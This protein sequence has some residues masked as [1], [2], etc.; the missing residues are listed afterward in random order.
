MPRSTKPRRPYKPGTVALNA[1]QIAINRVGKLNPQ[2]ARGQIQLARR[3]LQEFS[4]GQHCADH[5]RSLAD[6]A[7]MAETLCELGIGSGRAA[8]GVIDAA[9]RALAAVMTRQRERQTWTLY[10]AELDALGWLIS[11]HQTQ[12]QECDYGEFDTAFRRT[13]ERLAQ[14]RAGNAPRG[15]VVIIGDMA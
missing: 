7:N 6:T 1:V 4:A 13:R 2:D 14:A 10:P 3:A 12:L 5:W 11:L 8:M 9:Q 15:A